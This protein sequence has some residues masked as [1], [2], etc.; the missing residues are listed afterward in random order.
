MA[1][2]TTI[3]RIAA[4]LE[5]IDGV[6]SV[7]AGRPNDTSPARLPSF[8]ILTDAGEYDYDQMGGSDMAYITRQYR[9]VLL[10]ASWAVGMELASEGLCRPFFAAVEEAFLDRQ[11][12][13]NPRGQ[14][15]LNSVQWAKL[16][17]DTGIISITLAGVAYAGV[18]WALEVKELRRRVFA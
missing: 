12:L 2:D 4:I 9:L 14:N 5:D 15:Y 1:V 8:V 17:S 3:E 13:D 10:V 16:L 11:S 7:Y 6:V 18:Q